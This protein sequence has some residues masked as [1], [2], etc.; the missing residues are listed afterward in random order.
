[1]QDKVGI[2]VD[3]KKAVL[4]YFTAEGHEVKQVKFKAGK[5]LAEGRVA[6]RNR[7][8]GRMDWVADDRLQ[9]K[10]EVDRKGYYKD[11]IA[12]TDGCPELFVFG[13]AQAK[14]ELKKQLL[15]RKVPGLVLDVAASD[16]MTEAQI[17]ATA[18]AHFAAKEGGLKPTPRRKKAPQSKKVKAAKAAKPIEGKAPKVKKKIAVRSARKSVAANKGHKI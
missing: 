13:P 1:M 14:T 11:I 16:E 4:V 15:A 17:V 6:S 9:N 18:R 12:A 7:S 8:H 10:A 5:P 3:Y 2:W